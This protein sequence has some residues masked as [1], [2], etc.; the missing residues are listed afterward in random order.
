M[1]R[2]FASCVGGWQLPSG[3]DF[4]QY[5]AFESVN[6]GPFGAQFGLLHI[7]VVWRAFSVV[8]QLEIGALGP[9]L[10]TAVELS[11]A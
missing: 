1:R 7:W 11:G 5:F 3:L 6:S 4:G 8:V 2:S 9:T 10:E